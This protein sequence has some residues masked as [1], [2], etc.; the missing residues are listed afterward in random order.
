MAH[1]SCIDLSPDQ[2]ARLL[3]IARGSIRH[4]LVTQRPLR[5]APAEFVGTLGERFG[6]FVTLTQAG[7]LRGCVGSIEAA[8]PLAATVSRVAYSAAFHDSRFA[9]L[10]HPEL[11]QIRIEISI[12]SAPQTM[13]VG[14]EAELLATLKPLQDGLILEERGD[15]AIFLP[16]VWE[17]LSDP[18]EFIRELKRKAGLAEDYWSDSICFYRY[19]AISVTETHVSILA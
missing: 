10:T 3:E 19:E 16:K 9:K 8:E 6:T 15:R 17:K 4:G 18:A 1:S 14:S 5:V 2:K 12:L 7:A 13:T 11:D